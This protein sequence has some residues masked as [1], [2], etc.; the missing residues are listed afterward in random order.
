M[1]YKPE[2]T[3]PATTA[4]A[5]ESTSAPVTLKGTPKVA[6]IAQEQNPA[7]APTKSSPLDPLPLLGA[8]AICTLAV[9]VIRKRQ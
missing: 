2:S 1:A 3:I 7:A 5:G 9:L 4:A 6:S 8:L